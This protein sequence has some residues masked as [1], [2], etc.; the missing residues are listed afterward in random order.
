MALGFTLTWNGGSR[1]P[2]TWTEMQI[3]TLCL[4]LC[5]WW[6]QTILLYMHNENGTFL[7]IFIWWVFHSGKGLCIK[8]N[9]S[10]SC[11]Y[12]KKWTVTHT[13]EYITWVI[14][15]IAKCS[16]MCNYNYRIPFPKK[17]LI[18]ELEKHLKKKN[19]SSSDFNFS[20]F[21]IFVNWNRGYKLKQ[22]WRL[23]YFEIIIYIYGIISLTEKCLDILYCMQIVNQQ[24][25]SGLMV[26]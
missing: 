16:D 18:K 12:H 13:I 24:S 5:L 7:L 20:L 22:I 10:D 9:C 25:E 19:Y 11:K 1:I 26:L 15:L 2:H 4:K 8:I 17:A 14:L 6:W 21:H 23:I 3:W